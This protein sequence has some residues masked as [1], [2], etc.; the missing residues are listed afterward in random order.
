MTF[1][2]L[3]LSKN[4]FAQENKDSLWNDFHVRLNEKVARMRT[5]N[6]RDR[7]GFTSTLQWYIRNT[8]IER[9]ATEYLAKT[10]TRDSIP[11]IRNSVESL[12]RAVARA[13]YDSISRQQVIHFILD[14]SLSPRLSGFLL[15]DFDDSMK[16]KIMELF[17]QEPTEK[18]TFL[19]ETYV[20]NRMRINQFA[21]DRQI[22]ELLEKYEETK[23]REELWQQIY[24]ADFSDEMDRVLRE[25]LSSNT[26]IL[27]GQLNM[28]EAI[29]YLKE[30]ANDDEHIHRWAA[31]Y[32]LATMRVED[33]EERI[34]P[35]FTIDT[36]R[37]DILLARIINSQKV[38]YA[39]L[40]RVQSEKYDGDCPVAY[41]AISGLQNALRG[42]L[43]ERW[44]DEDGLFIPPQPPPPLLNVFD[45]CIRFADSPSQKVPINPDYIRVVV[46]WMRAEKGRFEL[47]EEVI[48]A[49]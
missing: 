44:V 5:V 7:S 23:S 4:I 34:L 1:L 11:A 3:L 31:S 2:L 45:V 43:I 12:M 13:S 16:Q 10:F 17:R 26:I 33:F 18:L 8:P 40:N 6:Y 19:V 35:R 30:I 46:E 25:R 41:R 37:D 21:V 29:P 32:A 36:H 49:F 38:W 39:Y 42:F 27:M 47:R 22:S 14:T 48:R 28:Q 20:R 24:E 15:S 9:R